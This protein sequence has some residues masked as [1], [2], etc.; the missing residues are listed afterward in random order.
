M[1]DRPQTCTIHAPSGLY[2]PSRF[3]ATGKTC[4]T[5]RLGARRLPVHPVHP[6]GMQ[7]MQEGVRWDGQDR[8]Y[9]CSR[10]CIALQCTPL[11]AGGWGQ[12]LCM[13]AP[14]PLDG[15]GFDGHPSDGTPWGGWAPPG[16]TCE[17][18]P[19][20]GLWGPRPPSQRTPSLAGGGLRTPRPPHP[21]PH[22]QPPQVVSANG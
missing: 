11:G 10:G 15:R 8:S 22:P 21:H 18:W 5:E 2:F 7:G 3:L 14:T 20:S 17:A 1:P 9:R 12:L 19:R 4:P 13:G 16:N 6:F